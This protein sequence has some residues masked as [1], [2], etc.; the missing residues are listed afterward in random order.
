MEPSLNA[1]TFNDVGF[2]DDSKP[3]LNVLYNLRRRS[4]LQ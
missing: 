4:F 2:K 1:K 3:S